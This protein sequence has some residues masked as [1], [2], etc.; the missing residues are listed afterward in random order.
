[1]C[2][3]SFKPKFFTVS[4]LLIWLCHHWMIPSNKVVMAQTE[5]LT[6]ATGTE[7]NDTGNAGKP[8]VRFVRDIETAPFGIANP[9]GLAFSTKANLFHVQSAQRA[10][11]DAPSETTVTPLQPLG[12]AAGAIKI[13]EQV[14]DPINMT[15]DSKWNRLLLLKTPDAQLLAVPSQADGKLNTNPLRRHQLTIAGLQNPQGMTVDPQSGLLYLLDAVGPRLF[16]IEPDTAGNFENAQIRNIDLGTT[17]IV[18][19]RGLAWE[20]SEQQLYTLSLDQ[21]TLYSLTS[22]GQ[23]M[24]T[25]NIAEFA[26]NN[27]QAMLFAPSGDMTDDPERLSLYIAEAGQLA[28]SEQTSEQLPEQNSDQSTTDT[29]CTTAAACP[30]QLYL[31]LVTNGGDTLTPGDKTATV[32]ENGTVDETLVRATSNMGGA[33]IELSLAA[34]A[35]VPPSPYVSTLVQTIDLA[36]ITPASPDPSGLTYLATSNTLLMTDGEVEE[37]VGGITH[38]QGANAWELTLNGS[39]VRTHNLSAIAPA[40][41]PLT[42]EPTGIAWNPH[43]GHYFITDDDLR[44]IYDLAPGNDGLLGTADDL[45]FSF[46]TLAAGNVDPEGIAYD[47]INNFLFVADGLNQEIYQYTINGTLVNHF[48]VEQYGIA[49]PESI[50]FNP[51]SG[52]LLILSNN[53]SRIIA[54]TTTEGALLR[55][56]NVAAANGRAPAGLAYGPASDGSGAKRYYIVDRGIDNNSNPTIVDG[57]LYEMT[58]PAALQPGYNIPPIVNAGPDQAIVLPNQAQLNATISDDG[59]PNPPGAIVT[60]WSQLSGPGTV[61]F[62]NA[63]AAVTSASFSM[64][65]TY[66]LRLEAFDG[67]GIGGDNI[68]IV[69]TGSSNVVGFDLRIANGEDDAEENTKNTVNLS[70]GDLDMMTDGGSTTVITNRFVGLRFPMLPLPPGSIVVNAHLQFTADEAHTDPSQFTIQ[71]EA[72]DNA[73]AFIAASKNLSNRL[74]TTSSVAWIP[75]S[76]LTGGETGPNQRTPNLASLI[77]EVI[78]RPGWANGNAL[79]ILISG[80]GQHV[81]RSFEEKVITAPL[82]HVEYITNQ[83]PTVTAGPAQSITLPHQAALDGTVSDDGFPTPPALGATWSQ[84]SGPGAVTFANAN[85]VDTTATFAAPGAYVLRL[86]ATDGALTTSDDMAVTVTPQNQPPTVSAGPDQSLALPNSASLDGTVSD[87]GLPT[88]PTLTTTWSKVSGP[89]AVTFADGN[90]VDTTATFAAPG[91][92]VLR[93]T[94]TDGALSASDE[95]TVTVTDLIFADSFEA[96]N[97]SAWSGSVIEDGNLSVSA[98][99]ALMGTRGLQALINDNNTIYVRDDSPV[100]EPRYRVRFY[101]DPNSIAMAANEMHQIFSG[102]TAAGTVVLQIEFRYTNS[103]AYQVRALIANEGTPYISSGWFTISDAPHALELD[104]RAA[105]APGANNGG[106]TFW[107][108]G[109]Q[110]ANV[111][112]I[113]NDT[114]RIDSVRMGAGSGIDNGTRGTYYF[115]AFVSTRQS[116]IGP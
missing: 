57:K 59:K 45:S 66:V 81:A 96:G 6:T 73:A 68:T 110:R 83:A 69:V 40:I 80:S 112:S 55:T 5:P 101:F 113:N 20:P 24:T 23:V 104:W 82:L 77:Q 105:T 95:I 39:V 54:E 85:A 14:K 60:H 37:T 29:L 33:I 2:M 98:S 109:V 26:F 34:P 108:D 79:A 41:K 62:G 32:D 84:V 8:F 78:N 89:D 99:A 22:D 1:M 35:A 10:G 93:L 86:T 58:A 47:S 48:D 115:D 9:A 21:Q 116:Y 31:P 70:S 63:N 15:F 75:P 3:R 42:N 111:T 38:F 7:K 46:D 67:E 90:A 18:N 13:T 61:T 36:A 11:Q 25:R 87:D 56:I 106:V 102:R 97:L 74:R 44:K 50:E 114:R 91:A 103:N 4:L 88:P 52:T 30:N 64:P 92:Y 19:P 72:S 49:D 17:G 53:V 65:G 51:D 28:D 107:I 94:A 43:N 100:A 16:V 71:A 12:R 27:P 76:W